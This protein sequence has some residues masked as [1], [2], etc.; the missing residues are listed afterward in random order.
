MRFLLFSRPLIVIFY[1]SFRLN[2]ILTKDAQHWAEILAHEDR[3]TYRQN[4]QYGENLYCL[5]SSDRNAKANPREVVRSWYDEYKEYNFDAEPRGILKAGQFTQLVWKS[6]KDLGVG[7]A[8]TKKGKVIVVAT[9]YP[10]GNIIGNFMIN[11]GRG[12]F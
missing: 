5:W 8:K 9:Y 2:K 7:M 12:R 6:S 11:V 4:S 3:F 1:F 10:R